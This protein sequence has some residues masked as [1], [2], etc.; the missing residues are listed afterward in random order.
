MFFPNELF[1]FFGFCD[2]AT[3]RRPLQCLPHEGLGSCR[4]CLGSFDLELDTLL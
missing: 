1:G 3:D 4:H 2:K